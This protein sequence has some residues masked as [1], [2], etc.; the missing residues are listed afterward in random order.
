MKKIEKLN[1]DTLRHYVVDEI[2]QYTSANLNG[3]GL[4]EEEIKNQREQIQN[5]AR[6]LRK[7]CSGDL[8]QREM[9]KEIVKDKILEVV[10]KE[11]IDE[12][13]S[14]D[15]EKGDP[16]VLFETI[17]YKM[18]HGKSLFGESPEQNELDDEF[19]MHAFFSEFAGRDIITSD[20]IR[21]LYKRKKYKLSFFE[22]IN[23]LAQILFARTYGLGVIDTLNYAEDTIEEIHLGMSGVL[24]NTYNYRSVLKNEGMKL[25]ASK[26]KVHVIIA[27]HTIALLFLSFETNNELIR[28]LQNLVKDAGAG[29][30]TKEN[31]RIITDTVD[32]RRITVARP[33]YQ[34]SWGGHVRI[35]SK[36]NIYTIN[37]W[38]PACEINEFISLL[39][40][41]G[42]NIAV[43]GEMIS[44]KTTLLRAGLA[45]TD[46]TKN[47]RIIERESFELDGR[48]YLPGRNVSSY[49]ITDKFNEDDVLAYIRK[50]SGHIFSVGEVNSLDMAN[51]SI[52][53]SKIVPQVLFTAH[54][55][56]TRAMI[57][58]FKNAKLCHGFTSEKLAEIEAA[59]AVDVNIHL[60]NDNGIRHVEW[61]EEIVPEES[62][63]PAPTSVEKGLENIQR[64]LNK[65]KNYRINRLYERKSFQPDPGTVSYQKL[66]NPSDKIMTK[67]RF[68][69]NSE[70]FLKL[71]EFLKKEPLWTKQVEER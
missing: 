69:M 70:D 6:G 62:E 57:E 2:N 27:G 31:P 12:C 33:P 1:L 35:P 3:M 24:N 37:E 47:I 50:T 64:Q 17:V 20:D 58:D 5:I 28:V 38:D 16:W 14:F 61:I 71:N 25:G 26:D 15:A 42:C 10:D 68:F 11:N 41:S 63:M 54:Y 7:C 36:A 49:R 45:E 4:S 32:G 52:N 18:T 13:I 67:A 22:K 51:L 48:R 59:R 29:D 34:D 30:I 21:E 44:G 43:T 19:S 39:F 8:G 55:N 56:T 46:A 60:V 23:V 65:S 53:L 9:T 66:H 40:R